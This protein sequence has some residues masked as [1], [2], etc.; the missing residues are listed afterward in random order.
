MSPGAGGRRWSLKLR[1]RSLERSAP[2]IMS[3]VSATPSPSSATPFHHHPP[4]DPLEKI[5][6]LVG[7]LRPLRNFRRREFKPVRSFIATLK[8]EAISVPSFLASINV[9]DEKFANFPPRPSFRRESG[10]LLARRAPFPAACA[11]LSA[12]DRHRAPSNLIED[13]SRV[14]HRDADSAEDTRTISLRYES[15]DE[16]KKPIN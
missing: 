2:T 3:D 10:L 16:P 5:D 8:D 9:R 15:K 1:A 14:S 13:L 6:D 11:T 7:F 4:R 12:A